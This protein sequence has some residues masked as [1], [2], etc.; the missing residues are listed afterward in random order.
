M[1]SFLIVLLRSSLEASL[2]CGWRCPGAGAGREAAR[3]GQRAS[4]TPRLPASRRR[5]ERASPPKEHWRQIWSNNPQE[6]LNREIRR[7]TDVAGIFAVAPGRHELSAAE[8]VVGRHQIIP[9][10]FQY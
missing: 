2:V 4:A 5:A 10:A 6:R 3:G 8:H 1:A 9:F 7:R